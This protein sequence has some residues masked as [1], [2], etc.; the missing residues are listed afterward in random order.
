M[1]EMTTLDRVFDE[2]TNSF[3]GF[4]RTFRNVRGTLPSK[5]TFPP[6]NIV[7]NGEDVRLEMA[8]AGYSEEDIDIEYHDGL[9]TVRGSKGDDEQNNGDEYIYRGIA[10]RSFER[11]FTL[12]DTV[13]VDDAVFE[14]GILTVYMHNELPEHKK[15]RK[16][17]ING[18]SD[19][20]QQLL[21]E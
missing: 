8:V 20:E 11:V 9:L 21:N 16:I 6:V 17:A 2:M 10:K 15:Y 12:A 14:N 5:Q 3:I 7:Q 1:N 18:N 4:D 19:D 13:V